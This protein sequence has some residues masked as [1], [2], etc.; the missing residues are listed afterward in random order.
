VIGAAEAAH[1][2]R[3]AVERLRGPGHEAVISA[4]AMAVAG[5]PLLVR[6]LDVPG[7]AYY[8]VPWERSGGVVLVVQVDAESGEMTTAAALPTPL[9]SLLMS[10]ADAQARV[11]ERFTVSGPPHLVWKP[12][13]ETMSP[14]QP[15]CAVPTDRGEVYV[16]IDGTVHTTL[17]E[18]GRGGRSPI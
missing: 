5:A 11:A 16:T 2:A 4:A 1:A 13:R 15:L 10:P 9:P 7:R 3:A 8:L 17:T 18:P 12:C 6:R 14:L